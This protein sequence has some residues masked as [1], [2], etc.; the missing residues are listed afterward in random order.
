MQ[1]FRLPTAPTRH[2]KP[3]TYKRT[4]TDLLAGDLDFHDQDG[5]L[6][7]HNF[8]AFPAKFPPQLPEKFITTLTESGEAVLD[9]CLGLDL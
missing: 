2:V 7:S 3:R 5:R 4:L 9:L 1:Q 6:A 8:H